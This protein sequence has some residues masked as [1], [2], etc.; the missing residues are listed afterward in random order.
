MAVALPSVI[1][2]VPGCQVVESQKVTWSEKKVK[3][4]LKV[5]DDSLTSTSLS[6]CSC[7]DDAESRAGEGELGSRRGC[8]RP[9]ALGLGGVVGDSVVAG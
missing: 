6:N 1:Q 7:G 9:Q 2:A 4:V 5:H 8:K 3:K